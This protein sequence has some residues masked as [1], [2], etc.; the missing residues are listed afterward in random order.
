M[1]LNYWTT[2]HVRQNSKYKQHTVINSR[3]HSTVK[4]VYY[5]KNC[6]ICYFLTKQ[7]TAR[8]GINKIQPKCISQYE[9]V[10]PVE[11]HW[12]P[13]TIRVSSNHQTASSGILSQTQLHDSLAFLTYQQVC[14][15]QCLTQQQCGPA[16][17]YLSF[18]HNEIVSASLISTMA[19]TK[20]SMCI[21]EPVNNTTG[22]KPKHNTKIT[23]STANKKQQNFQLI[24]NLVCL[25]FNECCNQKWSTC[26]NLQYL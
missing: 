14:G 26:K 18:P 20:L 3:V 19:G 16:L 21:S 12:P 7:N 5:F 8:L 23:I 25:N 13:G 6:N 10:S 17:H 11:F 1:E 4:T 2:K 22:T 15:L 9:K 24:S